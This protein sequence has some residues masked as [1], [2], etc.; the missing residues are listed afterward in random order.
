MGLLHHY[1]PNSTELLDWKFF[2]LAASNAALPKP[3]MQPFA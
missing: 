3:G 1:T 2:G